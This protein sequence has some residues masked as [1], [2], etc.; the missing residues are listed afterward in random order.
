M[1]I[2]CCWAIDGMKDSIEYLSM[3]FSGLI[4][5]GI[6]ESAKVEYPVESNQVK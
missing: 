5:G 3:C 4:H 6:A 1:G 2:I